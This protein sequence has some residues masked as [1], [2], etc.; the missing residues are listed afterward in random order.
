MPVVRLGLKRAAQSALSSASR[1]A[2]VFCR[3]FVSLSSRYRHHQIYCASV[4][5][6][7]LVLGLHHNAIVATIV[8]DTSV[9]GMKALWV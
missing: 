6:T 8:E 2:A 7:P 5:A 1:L 4:V 3:S 9:Q